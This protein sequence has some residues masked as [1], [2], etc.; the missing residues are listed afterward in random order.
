[1]CVTS[2]PGDAG[3]GV[4]QH[5]RAISVLIIQPLRGWWKGSM[6]PRIEDAG[7]YGPFHTI[8]FSVDCSTTIPHV[9]A[10]RPPAM[11]LA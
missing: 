7:H 4:G 9:I 3:P 1:M 2:C 10:R 8:P 5:R 6:Y 11:G